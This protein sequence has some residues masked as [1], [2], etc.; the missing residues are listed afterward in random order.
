MQVKYIVGVVIIAVFIILAAV[1]FQSSLTPYVSV[2]EAK[3]ADGT[4]Q[5]KGKRLDNGSFDI[6]KNMFSFR[7]RDDQGEEITVVYDGA[8]PGNFDQATH[9][10][11]IGKYSRGNFIAEK[12]L[13][14]CP[15]KYT[16]E[17]AGR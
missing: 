4:V 12:L 6:A 15:S 9:I 13:V 16:A 17:E 3:E 7:I 5:L 11:C 2:A 1:S 8:K 10:V 14:K